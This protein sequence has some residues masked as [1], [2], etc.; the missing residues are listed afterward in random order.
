MAT[1]AQIAP[2]IQA[3]EFPERHQKRE[4]FGDVSASANLFHFLREELEQVAK[5]AIGR[6]GAAAAEIKKSGQ[7]YCAI[8]ILKCGRAWMRSPRYACAELSVLN[9]DRN[10]PG[11]GLFRG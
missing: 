6:R 5:A 9:I 11:D 1:D 8:C 4:C 3:A 7:P 10:F 2:E